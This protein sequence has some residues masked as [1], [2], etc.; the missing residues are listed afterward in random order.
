MDE[1]AREGL[2]ALADDLE[3]RAAEQSGGPTQIH[4]RN[5]QS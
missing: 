5:T 1:F 3:R 2:L 4:I